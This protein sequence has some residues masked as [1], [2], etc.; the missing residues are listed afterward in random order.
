M[1]RDCLYDRSSYWLRAVAESATQVLLGA[2]APETRS[3]LHLGRVIG[4]SLMAQT[5]LLSAS[6][7]NLTL[8]YSH[9]EFMVVNATSRVPDVAATFLAEM[10]REGNGWRT[11]TRHGL[12]VE[13]QQSALWDH[14]NDSAELSDLRSDIA[15]G[16]LG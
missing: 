8:L 15:I 10:R 14:L 1:E 11:S 3:D 2:S 9:H 16:S 7:A 13:Q 4:A 12:D 6:A 5:V